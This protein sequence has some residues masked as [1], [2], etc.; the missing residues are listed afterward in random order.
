M[1]PPPFGSAT[2]I[3]VFISI[4][5]LNKRQSTIKPQETPKT[6]RCG[7]CGGGAIPPQKMCNFIP[8]LH[9]GTLYYH[10]SN[11]YLQPLAHWREG[12][13]LCPLSSSLSPLYTP[14]DRVQALVCG[15][16]TLSSLANNMYM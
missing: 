4:G 14:L 3:S 5:P 2:V 16:A 12:L 13:A 1:P 9:F 8:M 7:V 6:L 15:Y 10:P 11:P